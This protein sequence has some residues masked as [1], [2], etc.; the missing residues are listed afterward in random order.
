MG[1]GVK[2]RRVGRKYTDSCDDTVD[3]LSIYRPYVP[4]EDGN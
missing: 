3:D 1:G 4:S 2:R